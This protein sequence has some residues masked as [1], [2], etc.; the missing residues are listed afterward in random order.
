[1]KQEELIEQLWILLFNDISLLLV[2]WSMLCLIFNSNFPLIFLFF[3]TAFGKIFFF[4]FAFY[5]LG[6]WSSNT[7]SNL[8]PTSNQGSHPDLP[9]C[10]P[11]LASWFPEH[12]FWR[13]MKVAWVSSSSSATQWKQSASCSRS[14]LLS[15][16]VT[17]AVCQRRAPVHPLWVNYL[18]CLNAG[19]TLF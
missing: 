5:I 15:L 12:W 4:L 1:M 13:S 8:T 7:L 10:H 11:H 14:C 6:N 3:S 17:Q 16:A 19:S 18:C 2:M 9:N